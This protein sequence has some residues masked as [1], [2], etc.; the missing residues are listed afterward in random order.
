MKQTGG[1]RNKSAFRMNALTVHS[2]E[3]PNKVQP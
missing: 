2:E 1:L 3:V